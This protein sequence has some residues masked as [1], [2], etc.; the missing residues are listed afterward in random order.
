M[1]KLGA[2]NDLSNPA[3]R[4]TVTRRPATAEQIARVNELMALLGYHVTMTAGPYDETALTI[5]DLEKQVQALPGQAR[6]L[7]A[8]A[9]AVYE[10]AYTAAYVAAA[11][12]GGSDEAEVVSHATGAGRDAEDVFWAQVEREAV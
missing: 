9:T 3:N 6:D 5:T 10:K 11:N 1:Y 8:E 4:P 12:W 7:S 2:F